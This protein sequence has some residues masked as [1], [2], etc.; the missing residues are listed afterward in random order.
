VAEKVFRDPV[1]GDVVLDSELE[2]A[3]MDTPEF[4]RLRGIKQLGTASLVYP[5]A[6]HTRFEHSLGTAWLARQMASHMGLR[7]GGALYAAA[8]LHDVSHIPYGHTF[9]DE[10]HIFSRH[11]AP[12]RVRRLLTRGALGK[13]L[14]RLGLTDEVEAILCAGVGAPEHAVQGGGPQVS[15]WRDMVSG[16]ICADLLDYL[17]R[18]SYF[19]G[20]RVSY[21]AR[22]FR[23]FREDGRLYLEAQKNGILREDVISEIVNLLRLRYFLSERVYFHHSKTASGAM[24]SRAVECA[25]NAGLTLEDLC[26]L[27][28]DRLMMLLAMRYSKIKAV[29]ILLGHFSAHRLY[30]RAYVLTRLVGEKRLGEL[31]ETY[32]F[33]RQ[34]REEAEQSLTRKLRLKEGELIIYCPAQK[35]QLKEADVRVRIDSG[36]PRTLAE[37]SVPE[38]KVLQDKHRDLWK[39]YVFVAPTASDKLKAIG[40]ACEAYFQ[41]VNHLPAL[42]TGQLYLA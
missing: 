38:I 34:A 15:L 31:V 39:F 1:H 7:A 8:L 21:D 40:A 12:D 16:T 33:N 36:P 22:I 17:A 28:D 41:E 2:V 10:R 18:D 30:K 27:T 9:E 24:I 37:L 4:Q 29:D 25:V 19:C 11:D 3:L 26:E 35:M 5:G 42:Q 14:T 32:H 23:H 20:L 6:V 13:V